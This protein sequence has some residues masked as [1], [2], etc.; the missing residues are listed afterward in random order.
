MSLDMYMASMKLKANLEK[1]EKNSI[2]E[3][4]RKLSFRIK[5]QDEEFDY[6]PDKREF[7]FYQICQFAIDKQYHVRKIIYNEYGEMV[8]QKETKLKK[9]KL[10]NFLKGAPEYKYILYPA[11]NLN[12]IE[13]PKDSDISLAKSQ[14]LNNY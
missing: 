1:E 12:M 6:K 14:I 13:H 3:T 5:E 2:L 11:Y 7:T 10:N 8:R 4:D 9:N